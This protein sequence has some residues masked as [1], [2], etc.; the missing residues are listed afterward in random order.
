[1]TKK[2]LI[3]DDEPNIIMTLSFLMRQQGY[4]VRTA[5]DGQAVLEALHDECPDL[6]L[7]DVM[8]PNENGFEVCQRIRKTPEWRH[9]KIILLTA[10]GRDIDQQKGMA[11]G[12][13]DYLTKPFATQEVVATV[14]SL[15]ADA[16]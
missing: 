13:D 8:M 7:L 12:A 6:V 3:A 9:V 15:L 5:A 14:K 4:T 16:S 11:M 2:I 10:K 1:M